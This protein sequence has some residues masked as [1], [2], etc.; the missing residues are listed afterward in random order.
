MSIAKNNTA[1]LCVHYYGKWWGKIFTLLRYSK[2]GIGGK[3]SYRVVCGYSGHIAVVLLILK[4]SMKN[5]Y[6]IFYILVGRRLVDIT[7]IAEVISL[8]FCRKHCCFSE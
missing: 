3:I 4:H 1:A 8:H 7:Q 5:M 6:L 2:R